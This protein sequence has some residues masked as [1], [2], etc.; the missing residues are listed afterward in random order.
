MNYFTGR[1]A[2]N[3]VRNAFFKRRT[4]EVVEHVLGM[5]LQ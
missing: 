5:I 1:G 3:I 2:I 4:D